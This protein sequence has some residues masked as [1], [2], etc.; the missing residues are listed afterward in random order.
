MLFS[1]HL[2]CLNHSDQA[3]V[4]PFGVTAFASPSLQTSNPEKPSGLAIAS[5]LTRQRVLSL[6]F[7]VWRSASSLA[8]TFQPF[9]GST[10]R[11]QPLTIG[12]QLFRTSRSER[13]RSAT[14]SRERK[15]KDAR[16]RTEILVGT[17]QKVQKV[18]TG[19]FFT[20]T[21][22]SP[23]RFEERLLPGA[24]VKF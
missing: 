21:A 23:Q 20:F 9:N 19:P 11:S 16:V 6:S 2:M 8:S 15:R 7:R 18:R 14:Q 12:S 13:I 17:S 3:T 22:S 4:V 10:P 24:N 1:L 5:A